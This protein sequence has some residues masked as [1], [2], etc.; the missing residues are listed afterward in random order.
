MNLAELRILIVAENASARFGGEA[1]LPLHYFRY[2]RQ[3]GIQTWLVVHQRTR[4]ELHALLPAEASRMFFV[5]DTAMQRF[6]S[7]LSIH[8][9]GALGNFTSGQLIRFSTQLRA[10]DIARKLIAKF[11]I[12]VVHQPTPVSPKEF[13]LLYD[14]GAPVVIGPMNGAMSYPPA[15]RRRQGRLEDSFVTVG[16]A[17]A[18]NLN[19][20]FPGKIRASTLI[21]ANQRTE[22]ALPRGIRGRVVQLPENGVDLNLW[23]P[24]EY[25]QTSAAPARFVFAG[26][27]DIRKSIDLLLEAFKIVLQTTP[28]TLA[29]IGDGP[30]RARFQQQVADLGIAHA[31]SFLGWVSQQRCAAEFRASDVLVLPSLR[32]C[33]GAVVLEAMACALPV[34]AANWGGPADYLDHT[35]GILVPPRQR[36]AFI[37]DLAQAMIKLALDP[38]LR[39]DMGLGGRVRVIKEFSWL[40]KID[41]ILEIYAQTVQ[42]HE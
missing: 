36:G 12:D 27:F 28:A 34:I 1:I 26:R 25:S 42:P 5:P 19:P 14:L 24:R 31:T 33:G 3:R 35:C 6:A 10:R 32:E 2:L 16:R 39:K 37:A 30:D 8:L 7:R 38:D 40:G 15:F 41:R 18:R 13:S 29:I 20:L 23:Q 4:D 17:S 9:P 11:R 21:V 22:Q